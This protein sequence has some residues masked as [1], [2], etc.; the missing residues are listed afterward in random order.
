MPTR[1]SLV[2]SA[3]GGPAS[4]QAQRDAYELLRGE[5]KAIVKAKCDAL[6]DVA[7]LRI[8]VQQQRHVIDSM[9]ESRNFDAFQ[10]KRGATRLGQQPAPGP[11]QSDDEA[12]CVRQWLAA[13]LKRRYLPSAPLQLNLEAVGEQM[14]SLKLELRQCLHSLRLALQAHEKGDT[15]VKAAAAGL[16][17]GEGQ[18]R[19]LI[20]LQGWQAQVKLLQQQ[21]QQR[22]EEVLQLQ[23][24]LCQQQQQQHQHQQQQMSSEH[25][26]QIR[27]LRESLSHIQQQQ[28]ASEAAAAKLQRRHSSLCLQKAFLA[29]A[30]AYSTSFV[31]TVRSECAAHRPVPAPS[32]RLSPTSRLRACVFAVI[33]ARRLLEVLSVT[34][35]AAAPRWQHGILAAAR[36]AAAASACSCAAAAREGARD[37]WSTAQV[38]IS[39]RPIAAML[40]DSDA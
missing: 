12:G 40:R 4:S 6:N 13:T 27:F 32:A 3:S 2:R 15:P 33:A 28:R 35:A 34:T 11:G 14:K 29:R 26:I 39:P 17:D 25:A 10:V 9:E 20:E 36:A 38:I 8:I 22:N 24:K 1:T 16:Q 18:Q 21:L 19:L 7:A 31:S 30:E 23:E 37:A 5:L